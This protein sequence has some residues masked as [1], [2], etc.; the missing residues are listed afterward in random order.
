M[1]E[2]YLMT[3]VQKLEQEIKKLNREELASF[4]DWFRKYDSDGW[5]C[6]I[7]KDI[8]LGKLDNLA[9]QAMAA[10]KAGKSKGL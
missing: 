6:Q 10:H 9:E 7:A 3:K 8:N 1:Y 2:R 5:D 4:R